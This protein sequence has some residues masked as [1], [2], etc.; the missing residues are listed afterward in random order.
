MLLCLAVSQPPWLY[1][2]CKINRLPIILGIDLQ[3]YH[4]IKGDGDTIVKLTTDGLELRTAN[5]FRR[6]VE[7]SNLELNWQY[8]TEYN[9][10]LLP[11]VDGFKV[12]KEFRNNGLLIPI[13]VLMGKEQEEQKDRKAEQLQ[14]LQQGQG[15]QYYCPPTDTKDFTPNEVLHFVTIVTKHSEPLTEQ[16]MFSVDETFQLVKDIAGAAT[17]LHQM[18]MSHGD[19]KIDNIVDLNKQQMDDHSDGT[20]QIVENMLPRYAISEFKSVSTIKKNDET[21]EKNDAR[22]L[23][24]LSLKLLSSEFSYDEI[25]NVIDLYS[26]INLFGMQQ[27]EEGSKLDDK[28]SRLHI[29]MS[30]ACIPSPDYAITLT[31]AYKYLTCTTNEIQHQLISVDVQKHMWGFSSWIVTSKSQLEEEDL[32]DWTMESQFVQDIISRNSS[33]QSDDVFWKLATT[34]NCKHLRNSLIKLYAFNLLFGNFWHY[35]SRYRFSVS[36]KGKS[37]YEKLKPKLGK[38]YYNNL[39]VVADSK[40]DGDGWS[41]FSHNNQRGLLERLRVAIGNICC[42]CFGR[43]C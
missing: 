30:V 18:G 22:M 43:N 6:L 28:S 11:L 38:I 42:S 21:D 33:L 40:Y 15:I 37:E 4:Y 5:V 1:V 24:L 35:F 19:I 10:Y 41:H 3:N 8:S 36:T 29:F 14:L 27:K 13:G 34:A 26:K 12:A 32:V 16:Q 20:E 23:G 25:K 2:A 17:F 9:R 7:A 31:N 39:L